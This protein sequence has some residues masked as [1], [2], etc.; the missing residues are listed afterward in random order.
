MAINAF[1]PDI[2]I[3]AGTAGGFARVNGQIGDVYVCNHF[4]HHDRR[5]PVPGFEKY[6]K[7]QHQFIETSKLIAVRIHVQSSL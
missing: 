1:K 4:T 2:I 5:I 3:N 7:G 6:G